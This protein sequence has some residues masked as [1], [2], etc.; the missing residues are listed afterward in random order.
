MEDRAVGL[1]I[2]AEIAPPASDVTRLGD[3]G[4]DLAGLRP[5][6]PERRAYVHRGDL[7]VGALERVGQARLLVFLGEPRIEQAAEVDVAGVAA[8]GDNDALPGL[9]GDVLAA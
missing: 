9:D 4:A 1:K 5:G 6:R 7:S 8:G 2:K 3:G